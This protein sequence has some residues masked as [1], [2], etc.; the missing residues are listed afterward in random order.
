MSG[1]G[2]KHAG[3]RGGDSGCPRA[4]AEEDDA[5]ESIRCGSEGRGCAG[6]GMAVRA[7]GQGTNGTGG[8]G[9][10]RVRRGRHPFRAVARAALSHTP[11]WARCHTPSLAL[12]SS[13]AR[14]CLPARTGMAG[15]RGRIT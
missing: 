2:L 14:P 1:G 9:A 6:R 3:G 5:D 13:L 4:A 12:S 8:G 11:C 10:Y 15:G 7:G